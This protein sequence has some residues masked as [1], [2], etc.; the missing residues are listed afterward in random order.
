M[1]TTR[2]IRCFGICCRFASKIAGLFGDG[3]RGERLGVA[4]EDQL[5]GI[6][7]LS[8]G[9]LKIGSEDGKATV[10]I[11]YPIHASDEI[12]QKTL[13]VACQDSGVDIEIIQDK[14]HIYYPVKAPLVQ[15]LLKVYQE[16][17][18]RTEAPVVIGGGTYCRAV[19]NFVAYGPVFPGQRELAHEPDEY[20]GVEDLILT[21]KIYAQ[22]LY[23]L[24]NM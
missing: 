4:C 21:A 19:D 22:A 13:M 6:L 15:E 16:T 2:L 11:R 7:T 14:K 18:G 8:L 1:G 23:A 3:Y 10:E 20:I 17:T 9:V 5:S 12:I 24:L